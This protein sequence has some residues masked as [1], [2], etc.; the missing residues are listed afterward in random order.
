M[1]GA[2]PA[3]P[4]R[5][6]RLGGA[7]HRL[8][9]ACGLTNL[10]DG[11]LAT[12]LPLIAATLTHD[13]LA[14]SGLLAARFL[15]WLLVAPLSGVLLDRV[16]RLRAMAAANAVAAAAVAV[17]AA[18]VALGRAELWILYTVLFLV[19]ACE[20]VS[21]PAAR[22]SAAR[23]VPGRLLDRANGRL[24]G[25]HLVAQDC[26]A[27]PVAG[28][29]FAV[30]ALLPVA[31]TALSYA[32]CSLLVASV[33]LLLRRRPRPDGDADAADAEREPAEG[34]LRSLRE[35]LAHVFGDRLILRMMFANAGTM[36]GIQMATAVMVL[37]VRQ[38]LEVPVALYGLFIATIAVGGIAGAAAASRLVLAVG[39]RT[40][41]TAGYAGMGAG[42]AA[43]GLTD[44]ARLAA[45]AW[46]L[47]G[48][49]MTTSN[50]AGSVFFQAVVPEHLRGR[51]SAAYRTVGWGL[52]PAG[53]LAGGLL[54][55]IDLGLPYLAGG[56]LVLG[57]VLVFWRTIAECARLCDKAAARL[58]AA[59]AAPR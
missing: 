17:L 46:A 59:D 26:A 28:M 42:L 57:T 43:M 11:M 52:A 50:I 20:T 7:F 25:M 49:S 12:A 33:V 29:L 45:A 8:L 22:I 14:V 16:D 56:L 58:A 31:G 27:K 23:L 18:V 1:T 30:A 6:E 53:A 48:V 55:R 38:V 4:E 34:V 44:D 2:P 54:G 10:G 35:G 15:P 19:V 36:A 21:D 32:L 5:S 13:P 9:A 47:V 24:E 3:R 51:V 39:R 41:M 40:V 37:H